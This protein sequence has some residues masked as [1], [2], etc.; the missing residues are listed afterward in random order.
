MLE[1]TQLTRFFVEEV[2]IVRFGGSGILWLWDVWSVL[3]LRRFWLFDRLRL[4]RSHFFLGFREARRFKFCA[5]VEPERRDAL[6][7][8]LKAFDGYELL[9][10][11][12]LRTTECIGLLEGDFKAWIGRVCE[13]N[14]LG[15]RIVSQEILTLRRRI[16][17]ETLHVRKSAVVCIEEHSR[18]YFVVLELLDACDVLL[19]VVVD[20]EVCK[21]E[22]TRVQHDKDV[23]VVV[24]LSEISAMLVVVDTL[25]VGVVPNLASAQSRNATALELDAQDVV[26][27][28]LIAHAGAS[29]DGYF[30]EILVELQLLHLCVGLQR[31]T[32]YLCLTVVIRDFGVPFVTSYS[33][34]RVIDVTL[35]RLMNVMPDAPSL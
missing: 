7:F 24:E 31:N 8:G 26:L 3:R 14:K 21:V 4:L 30:A 1:Q 22:L 15:L 19:V 33:R 16:H 2:W 10:I 28:Q 27:R 6:A 23:F 29:L 25:H 11:Y 34:S 35:K 20:V 9:G 12:L 13:A 5:L 18:P 32:N 17:L